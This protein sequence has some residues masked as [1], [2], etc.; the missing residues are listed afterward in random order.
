MEVVRAASPA[1]GVD[2][3][4]RASGAAGDR[5]LENP[6]LRA[7]AAAASALV[8]AGCFYRF[9]LGTEAV[10]ASCFAVVLVLL[11]TIDLERRVIPNRI[12]LPATG[13]ILVTQIALSPDRALEWV[14]AALG[15]AL[16]LLLPLLI[17]PSGMG[18]GDV[19]LALLLGA[20]LGWAVVP[21]L[22]VGLMAAFVA[23]VVVL[24][25]GGLAARKTALPFG[26]F[27][28]LGGLVALFFS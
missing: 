18:M 2:A 4:D 19:K 20:G 23:A 27:L 26:P 10:V 8:V 9:G 14:A 17:Y 24:V 3:P 12:V 6:R 5:L 13:L 28:A 25:R 16:F 21:A 1:L 7:G 11:A 15:A 22:F